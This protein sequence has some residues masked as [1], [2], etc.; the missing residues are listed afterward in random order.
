VQVTGS[1][2]TARRILPPSVRSQS[3]FSVRGSSRR[4]TTMRFRPADTRVINRRIC[5]LSCH[6]LCCSLVKLGFQ[7]TKPGST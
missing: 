4:I 3:A 2:R 1:G 7:N 6:P 5:L